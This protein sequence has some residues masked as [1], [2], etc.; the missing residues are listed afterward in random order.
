MSAKPDRRVWANRFMRNILLWT[1]P[2]AG[3]W[4]LLVP[5]YNPF[6]TKA[7]ENL[8]RLTER[9]PVTRLVAKERHH[10]LVTRTDIPSRA[11]S[12]VR[13][14]DSHF[15]LILTGAL[16][17]AVPGVRLRRRLENLGWA[18]LVSVF[19]HIVLL[20]LWV[21]FIYATQLGTWSAENYSPFARELWGMAKHLADLPFKF[22]LPL[23]LWSVFYLRDLFGQPARQSASRP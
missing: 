22:A 21:Q 6:L 19:F 16:F 13:V 12:S 11:L 2:V 7:A 15:P 23:I 4:L 9:P 3:L 8:V 5:L 1:L 14:T 18:V 10:F 17:L 20:F